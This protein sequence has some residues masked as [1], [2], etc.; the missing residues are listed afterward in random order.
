MRRAVLPMHREP[1][2]LSQCHGRLSLLSVVLV[3]SQSCLSLFLPGSLV[4]AP[5]A[6]CAR[7]DLHGSQQCSCMP[8]GQSWQ[9]GRLCSALNEFIVCISTCVHLSL[10]HDGYMFLSS[11]FPLAIFSVQQRNAKLIRLIFVAYHSLLLVFLRSLFTCSMQHNRA[12]I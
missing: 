1:P 10:L 7:M 11:F 4:S 9:T 2:A 3:L 8:C 5:R 12:F 6:A